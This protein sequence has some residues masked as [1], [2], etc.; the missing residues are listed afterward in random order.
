MISSETSGTPDAQFF[1][2][3]QSIMF[4]PS[5]W[6]C[7]PFPVC[8]ALMLYLSARVHI[9]PVCARLIDSHLMIYTDVLYSG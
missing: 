9:S 5:F 4:D 3:L 1:Q 2:N 7:L 6:N 8:C